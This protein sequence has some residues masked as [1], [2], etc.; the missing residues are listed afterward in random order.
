MEDS[1]DDEVNPDENHERIKI[2][3]TPKQGEEHEGQKSSN[4]LEIY[5]LLGIVRIL[6]FFRNLS[7]A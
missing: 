3:R 7:I 2:S 5:V 6:R 4:H 1:G